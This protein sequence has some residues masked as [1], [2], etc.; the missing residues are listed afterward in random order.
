MA[1][2]FSDLLDGTGRRF[3]FGLNSAP[4]GITNAAPAILTIGGRVASI[5]EQAT[6][7]RT[8]A[9]AML[10]LIGLSTAAE[11]RLQPAPA[12]LAMFATAPSLLTMRVITNALPPDY[13][14][15]PDLLPT[16]VYIQ[17]I[18]PAPAVLTINSLEHNITQGGNIGF[19]SPGRA[20]LTLAGFGAN[21]PRESAGLALLTVTGYAPTTQTEI[22]ITP[23]PAQLVA[24]GLAGRLDLPF[25]WVDEDPV[26][27]SIWIDDP[28]A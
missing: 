24:S 21:F 20:L 28:R 25:V 3:Y 12:S 5:Q 16:I 15:L 2:L 23:D 7:F 9:T 1:R 27:P 10:T 6:V 19:V 26:P 17:T 11:P 13:T 14:D 4:G 8:P 22:R 18:S